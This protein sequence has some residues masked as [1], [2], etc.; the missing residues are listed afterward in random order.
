M[1]QIIITWNI[2]TN[3]MRMP[4][5]ANR[6]N[7]SNGTD[8]SPM[9]FQHIQSIDIIPVEDI[10]EIITNYV[11]ETPAPIASIVDEVINNVEHKN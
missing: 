4:I 5:D 3:L 6:I 2:T 8:L 1:N 9:I 7:I 11:T 10:Y